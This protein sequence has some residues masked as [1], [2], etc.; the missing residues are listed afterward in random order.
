MEFLGNGEDAAGSPSKVNS[1]KQRPAS[2]RNGGRTLKFEG[3]RFFLSE[4]AV[5]SSSAAR[6][7][8]GA[9]KVRGSAPDAITF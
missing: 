4:R 3:G 1:L 8:A 6:A 7:G 5:S 2:V 9:M